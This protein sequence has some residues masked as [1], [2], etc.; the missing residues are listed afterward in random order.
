[1][2][3]GSAATRHMVLIIALGAALLLP[4]FCA[5]VQAW[6]FS[7]IPPWLGFNQGVKAAQ[8]AVAAT[9]DPS[10]LQLAVHFLVRL[11][12]PAIL[13]LVWILGALLF[14]IRT[15]G[16]QLGLARVIRKSVPLR[17]P[18]MISQIQEEAHL[19]G[20]RRPVAVLESR[21]TEVPFTTGLLHPRVVLSPDYPDWSP[22]RRWAITHHEL[23]HVRR[24]DT[25]FQTLC[26]LINAVY[27]FHPLV[28]LIAREMR[29]ERER[30]CDDYVLAA[31]MR[32]SAYAHELLKIASSLSRPDLSAALAL[33]RR[34]ELEGRVMALLNPDVR[35]GTARA[36]VTV[37]VAA[38]TLCIALPLAAMHP[39][40]RHNERF[41]PVARTA[42]ATST[43][44]GN[45]SHSGSGYGSG[46]GSGSGGGSSSSSGS[47]GA[48]GWSDGSAPNAAKRGQATPL[49]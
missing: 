23:A 21:D 4:I 32:P 22:R 33:A 43:T 44:A 40:R 48:G 10:L 16:D 9:A 37:K 1:M 46:S 5:F 24:L 2:R 12:W 19:M 45:V 25:L 29:S 26:H 42:A 49:S 18:S 8:S 17:D 27:W 3:R 34:S 6:H 47:A 41:A 31:G 7:I 39:A 15:L 11:D 13:S 35:R 30:A 36:A 20:I 38:L 28:W 14:L